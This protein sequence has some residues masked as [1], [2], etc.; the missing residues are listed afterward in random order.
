[1]ASRRRRRNAQQ[2]P[3]NVRVMIAGLVSIVTAIV[4]VVILLT[5]INGFVL[6]TWKVGI[7]FLG[8]VFN[9]VAFFFSFRQL[10]APGFDTKVT[11][12]CTLVSFVVLVAY[13]YIYILG[14]F[15]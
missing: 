4:L 14:F 11:V 1:M 10:K 8:L 6:T 7:L 9:L 5:T 13:L 2:I 15:S 12:L 3:K